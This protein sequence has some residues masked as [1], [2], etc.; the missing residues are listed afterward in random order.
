MTS[1]YACA[2][3]IIR[4]YNIMKREQEILDLKNAGGIDARKVA[5]YFIVMYERYNQKY[6]LNLQRLCFLVFL[7]NVEHQQNLKY[8]KYN[9]TANDLD[10]KTFTKEDIFSTKNGPVILT[11]LKH[12]AKKGEVVPYH[13]MLEFEGRDLDL[14][15]KYAG[16]ILR[17]T[18]DVSTKN[19]CNNFLSINKLS[20]K[21]NT[22]LPLKENILSKAIIKKIATNDEYYST[23]YTWNT[24]SDKKQKDNDNENHR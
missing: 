19:L 9:N 3:Y 21:T 16:S 10:G 20:P 4:Q 6:E 23:L 11:L 2:D 18:R 24:K 13:P 8:I 12:Y 1:A 14:L 7:T 17:I 22:D 15:E 5:D